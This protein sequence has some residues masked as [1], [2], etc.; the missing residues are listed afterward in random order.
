MMC[1]T[2]GPSVQSLSFPSRRLFGSTSDAVCQERQGALQAYLASLI[3][4]CSAIPSCPLHED[5]T[6]EAL[7]NFS[8]FFEPSNDS[9]ST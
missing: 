1:Q 8:Y 9:E 6:R 4:I 2:Y 5:S 3:R 7:V